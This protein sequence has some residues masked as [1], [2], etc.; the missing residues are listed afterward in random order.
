MIREITI[1]AAGTVVV[2]QA[3]TPGK[4][5]KPTIAAKMPKMQIRGV[6][7]FTPPPVKVKEPVDEKGD[8]ARGS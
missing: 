8:S 5:L 2:S 6:G 4:L 3:E 7:T 1:S